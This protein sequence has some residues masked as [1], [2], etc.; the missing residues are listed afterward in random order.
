MP[1]P[2]QVC[3]AFSDDEAT[4]GAS[5][6]GKCGETRPG[7]TESPS[8]D[9]SPAGITSMHHALVL[10]S[11]R[12]ML[13]MDR[14]HLHR[15]PDHSAPGCTEHIPPPLIF[16]KV[17]KILLIVHLKLHCFTLRSNSFVMQEGAPLAP[18]MLE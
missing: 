13:R 2:N 4:Q 12:K 6:A 10:R 9:D 18:R 7:G 8:G 11:K 16:D 17:Q 3:P 14:F 5:L 1:Q 15:N